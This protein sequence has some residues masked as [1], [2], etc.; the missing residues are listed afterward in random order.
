MIR[1]F[2]LFAG[3]LSLAAC[4]EVPQPPEAPANQAA[5]WERPVVIPGER[6]TPAPPLTRTT[7]RVRIE[8][9]QGAI[10]VALDG[11]RAPITTS[12]FLRYV[13]SGRFDG[14]F[15]YRAART[16][17]MPGRGFIQ[18]GIDRNYRQMFP[19]I[20][21]E[22]TTRTGL[23]HG[24]GAISMA[25]TPR[26]PAIG[27]FFI[28]SEA[29]PGLDA[30]P[31]YDGYAVFGQVTEGLDTVRRILASPTLANA[32]RGAMRGQMIAAPVRIVRARRVD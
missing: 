7:V 19:P 26:G 2:A 11:R 13:D 17:G 32:G 23:T 5:A 29:I 14:T 21:H 30:R 31:D 9:E 27:E 20:E 10:T 24:A 3:L 12:N 6:P 25:H 15:F 18:G 22:P 16:R 8:T 4:G 28:T 1:L